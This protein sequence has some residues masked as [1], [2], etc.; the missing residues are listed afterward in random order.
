M[1]MKKSSFLCVCLSALLFAAGALGMAQT[2]TATLSGQV[3][4]ESGAVLPG[5][6]LTVSNTATGVS[7]TL[8]TDAGGRFVAPQL[9]PGSYEVTA[10]SSGF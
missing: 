10:T 6:Q 1:T 4:D 2:T 5:A 7:R 8:V 9:A 3:T